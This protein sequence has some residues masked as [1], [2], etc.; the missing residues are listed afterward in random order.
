MDARLR[1][2]TRQ[3]ADNR[4]EYCGLGQDQEPL[5]FHVEHIIPLRFG[6]ANTQS[7]LETGAPWLRLRRAVFSGG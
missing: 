5:T 2:L 1:Q 4:C 6:R 7:R 3:R